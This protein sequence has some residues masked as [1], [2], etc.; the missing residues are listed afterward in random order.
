[1]HILLLPA[2]LADMSSRKP[3]RNVAKATSNPQLRFIIHLRPI[4][5]GRPSLKSIEIPTVRGPSLCAKSNKT[6]HIYTDGVPAIDGLRCHASHKKN[7]ILDARSI[8]SSWSPK[9]LEL[10]KMSHD[11]HLTKVCFKM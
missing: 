9:L 7:I 2:C 8:P 4:L 6:I 3:D 10:I 5:Q 11:L 1:M